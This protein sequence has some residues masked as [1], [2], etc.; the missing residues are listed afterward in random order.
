MKRNGNG[1]TVHTVAVF[2][3]D[4]TKE[5]F[6]GKTTYWGSVVRVRDSHERLLYEIEKKTPLFSFPRPYPPAPKYVEMPEYMRR[7]SVSSCGVNTLPNGKHNGNG[8]PAQPLPAFA[9]VQVPM[10]SKRRKVKP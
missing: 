5:D 4:T 10:V 8:H 2:I 7:I 6:G 9:W 3:R 1:K